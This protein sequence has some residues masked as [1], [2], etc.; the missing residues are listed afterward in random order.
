M[1]A[2]GLFFGLASGVLIALGHLEGGGWAI[3]LAGIC[4]IMDGRLA[5]A[6]KVASPYGKFIDST[7]DRFVETFAF[8]GFAGLLRRAPL[9]PAVVAAGPLR[10]APRQLRPGP[11]RDR[12]RLRLRRAHAARRAAGAPDP[13]LPAR[14]DAQPLARDSPRAP[15]S[16][17]CWSSR[18]P[19]PS[20]PPSTGRPGSR[21]A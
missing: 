19:A 20:A 16:S 9:G 13:R 6:L 4:D 14:P 17:G 10:V 12:R 11:R 1:N 18:R 8:L 21:A 2:A 5:R 3:V 15:C 7:L